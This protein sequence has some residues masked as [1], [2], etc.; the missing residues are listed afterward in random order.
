MECFKVPL[1]YP[2]L[3]ISKDAPC[4]LVQSLIFVN[5]HA[6]AIKLSGIIMFMFLFNNG[7]VFFQSQE[8][9]LK[10]QVSVSLEPIHEIYGS[11]I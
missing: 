5:L 3:T 9:K 8:G 10:Y 7:D 6:V 4:T 11:L 2:T 1:Y